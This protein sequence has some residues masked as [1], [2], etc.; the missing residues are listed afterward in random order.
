MQ[1][2]FEAVI[3]GLVQGITEFIPVSSSG[4]L[5][6][7]DELLGFA[8]GGFVFDTLLNIGTLLALTLYFRRDLA[9]LW[10]GLWQPE[11]Y[12]KT[13]WLIILATLPA[14]A[15]GLFV[16]TIRS[17]Y[18]VIVMLAGVGVLMLIAERTLGQRRLKDIGTADA[19]TIGVA[20]VLAFIPGTSRSGITM[21]AGQYRGLS[22]GAAARFSFLLALPVLGGGV[23]KVALDPEVIGAFA[24]Q[25]MPY[26]AGIAAAFASGYI[27]ISFM[28]RFL[29]S[30][31]LSLFAWY[32]IALAAI[33]L[34]ITL[35]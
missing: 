23:L 18:V 32:R 7:A 2:L 19:L 16:P 29:S 33:L 28:L 14:V 15:V 21:V 25:P 24:L 4:H 34:V 5:I 9:Q 10:R 27:A 12:G 30:H 20:Q 35:V 13:S 17:I 11:Q 6:I 31:G 1:L 8:T 22:H 3:L 26:L